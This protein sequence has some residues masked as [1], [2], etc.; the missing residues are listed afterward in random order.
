MLIFNRFGQLV[1][2]GNST[3]GWDGTQG[4]QKAPSDTYAYIMKFKLIDGSID[5]RKGTVI[6]IR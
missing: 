3:D 5:Q 6:L 2:Q 1:Y 4:G